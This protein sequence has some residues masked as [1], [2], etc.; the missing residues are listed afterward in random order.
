MITVI[1]LNIS[2]VIFAYLSRYRQIRYGLEISFFLI[3]LFLALRYNFGNDYMGYLRGFIE[4]NRY[5]PVDFF[6]KT[7]HFEPGWIFL[8]RIFKP[9]GF[10]TMVAVL[11]FLYCYSFR[12]LIINYNNSNWYWLSLFILI[13]SPNLML[14]PASAMRQSLAC[15]IFI[16]SL[17]FVFE[18]SF[19]PFV[20]SILLA[21]LF[22]YSILVLLPVY[23]LFD[24]TYSSKLFSF[25]LIASYVFVTFIGDI[26]FP[27]G[28]LFAET[29]FKPYYDFYGL[30]EDRTAVNLLSSLIRVIPF[31]VAVFMRQKY[32]NRINLFFINLFILSQLLVQIS[33]FSPMINRFDMY[34][35][36]SALI[37]IPLIF[38]FLWKY[39]T[40][41]VYCVFYLIYMLRSF[42]NFFSH[43]I[44][45][46]SYGTY[47]TIFK[48]LN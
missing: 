33:F 44:W 32:G 37:A 40:G 13:V 27:Y 34:F 10:F 23:F 12:K 18:R 2:V 42:L 8:C 29:I 28:I 26:L 9:L 15:L 48:V 31:I 41:R 1:I 38:K 4:I 20:I 6:D 16:F 39:V 17:K 25:I 5:S 3:F 24:L 19:I 14:I 35:G 11:S 36:I 21:S 47:H 30:E 43:D 7:L 46:E 22:H 45:R